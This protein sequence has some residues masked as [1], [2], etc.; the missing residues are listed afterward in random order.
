MSPSQT[1]FHRLPLLMLV[2]VL[3]YVGALVLMPFLTPIAWAGI[4]VFITWPLYRRLHQLCGARRNLSAALMTLFMFLLSVGPMAWLLLNLQ[5]EVRAIYQATTQF[6][7]RDTLVL[8]EF[9]RSRLPWLANELERLWTQWH[10]SPEAVRKGLLETLGMGIGQLG[11]LAGG[12]GRNLAKAG[13]TLFVVFFFYRD[14]Q[15]LLSQLRLALYKVLPAT[16]ERYLTASADMTRA[17]VFGIVLTALAQAIVAGIGYVIVGVPNPIFL[18]FFTFLVS[19]IPFGAPLG[20]GSVCLWLVAQGDIGSAIF[21]AL[22]GFILVSLVDNVVRP[23]V[24]SSSAHISFLAVM[25]GILGGLMAFGAIGLFLGPVILA[26]L[27]SFWQAWLASPDQ[28]EAPSQ[29]DDQGT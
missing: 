10:D 17:V 8:P 22:W 1:L 26:V 29:P 23:L 21:L 11:S 3:G 9:L 14:G 12:I 6:L 20:W 18:T 5:H 7:T 19:V 16:G 25:F 4:V 15:A 2:L 13:I 28:D 27:L 24:I